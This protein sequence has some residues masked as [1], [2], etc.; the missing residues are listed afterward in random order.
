MPLLEL[1]DALLQL[2]EPLRIPLSRCGGGCSCSRSCS[3]SCSCSCFGF[4]RQN[5][6]HVHEAAVLPLLFILV[7]VAVV[8]ISLS[9]FL[10]EA[11]SRRDSFLEEGR[12]GRAEAGADEARQRRRQ[13][14]H[15]PIER[16]QPLSRA[17]RGRGRGRWWS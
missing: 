13:R 5:N 7:V 2:L 14:R 12:I 10:A 15:H 3:C 8:V 4:R 17:R 16:Y 6:A 11:L 9:S 1:A